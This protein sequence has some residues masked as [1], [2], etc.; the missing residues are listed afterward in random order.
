[1]NRVAVPDDNGVTRVTD[2]DDSGIADLDTPE[3]SDG[4]A[5]KPSKKFYGIKTD[6]GEI[7]TFTVKIVKIL[8]PKKLR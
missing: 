4:K 8:T 5:N 6:T 2:L 1:M 7:L 3:D